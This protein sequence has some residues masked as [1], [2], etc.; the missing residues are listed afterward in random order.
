MQEG[1]HA[2]ANDERE[3][4]EPPM[5]Q[6]GHEQIWARG[7][8][9]MRWRPIRPKHDAKQVASS[10]QLPTNQRRTDNA[11]KNEPN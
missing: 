9:P 7:Q 5:S 2:L 6:M 10:K 4:L 11:E 1:Y 3:R 8:L